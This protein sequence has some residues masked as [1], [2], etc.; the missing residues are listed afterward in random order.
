MDAVKYGFIDEF[1]DIESRLTML[2]RK[3]TRQHHSTK[4]TTVFRRIS[5]I[6]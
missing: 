1:L 5:L 4:I 2:Q 6:D 3:N